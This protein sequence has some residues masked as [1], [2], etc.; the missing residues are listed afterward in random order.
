[1]PSLDLEIRA[2]LTR[3][4]GGEISLQALHDWLTPRSWNID[5]RSLPETAELVHTVELELSE[6]AHGDWTEEELK[7]HL[8]PLVSTYTV[9]LSEFPTTVMTRSSSTSAEQSITLE[10]VPP[11]PYVDIRPVMVFG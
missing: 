10:A 2:Q 8:R 5:R 11:E 3:Y 6:F 1:M 9:S 4:L 7:R